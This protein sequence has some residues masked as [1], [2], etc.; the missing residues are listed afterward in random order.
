MV[1][2]MNRVLQIL[3]VCIRVQETIDFI[4]HN[5]WN[6]IVYW[7]E[8]HAWASIVDCELSWYYNTIGYWCKYQFMTEESM[9]YISIYIEIRFKFRWAGFIFNLSFHTRWCTRAIHTRPHLKSPGVVD[10]DVLKSKQWV[11][12]FLPVSIM[13]IR[14]KNVICV[15]N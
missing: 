8:P 3:L 4:M 10:A 7:T 11:P 2:N 9:R 1:T 6:S 5:K 12:W 15:G 13:S 14:Y